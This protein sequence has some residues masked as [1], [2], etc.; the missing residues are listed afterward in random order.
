[1]VSSRLWNYFTL[2]AES[3]LLGFEALGYSIE[4]DLWNSPWIQLREIEAARLVSSYPGESPA[5]CR[6][7]MPTQT[8]SLPQARW[9]PPGT[10]NWGYMVP[11]P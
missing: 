10:I 7:L 11:R 9:D 8:R 2:A 5:R 1:M 3:C 6:V 4:V